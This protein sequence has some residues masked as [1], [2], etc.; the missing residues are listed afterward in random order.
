MANFE[1]S[2][3]ASHVTITFK[4]P[5]CGVEQTTDALSVPT[6]DFLSETHHDS[7]NSDYFEVQC[8]NCDELF[9]VMLAT[10]IYGG[11]GEMNG[12][13]EIIN[14]DEEIPGDDDDYYD[15][16]L[17]KATH[18]E[19]D[20]TLE[21]I[22]PLTD[23]I[24]THLYRLLYANIISK[25]EAFLS[26]TIIKQVLSSND[27]KKK[28]L[29]TY[30]PLAEQKFPMKAIYAKY[31]ALDTII[32][33]ALTSIVY[34]DLELVGKIYNDTLGVQLPKVK[35]IDDAIQIRH[36]IVHRNGKD[37]D[38]NLV[39]ISKESVQ[40]LAETVSTF[41]FDVENQLP[42]PA[43]DAIKDLLSETPFGK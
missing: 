24:K 25:L 34:H 11:E 33:G 10:G 31:D 1:Y 23:E 8:E 28:F 37:K 27:N 41:M 14:I 20:E 38:G 40:N 39:E 2:P 43:L 16:Q 32:R 17:Y 42:N 26:D 18:S 35:E 36:H 29:Q 13:N 3:F 9:E 12:V 6:P 7:I 4:C 30:E 5:K 22:E 19:I 21:A 15:Y